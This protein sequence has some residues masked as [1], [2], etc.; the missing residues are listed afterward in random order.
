MSFFP[1]WTRKRWVCKTYQLILVIQG[2]HWMHIGDEWLV[3]MVSLSSASKQAMKKTLPDIAAP[4]G[5]FAVFE[6]SVG[7]LL[8]LLFFLVLHYFLWFKFS[9]KIQK[10]D[11]DPK[12]AI[13]LRCFFGLVVSSCLSSMVFHLTTFLQ[14][15]PL[16]S[17]HCAKNMHIQLLQHLSKVEG[18]VGK[19]ADG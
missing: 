18:K 13:N 9:Q 17:E 4:C 6:V 15:E 12:T 11:V 14:G 10:T 19:V 8:I 1:T 16:A 2:F 3:M 7:R 5:V